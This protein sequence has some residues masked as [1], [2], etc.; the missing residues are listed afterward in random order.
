MRMRT[1]RT[2]PYAGEERRSGRDRRERGN[3]LFHGPVFK[4][5]RSGTRR[6]AD[7]R[8]VVALD[9]YS[10]SL[11]VAITIVLCLSLLD[12]L[13]TLMLISDGARE[14]N[15]VMAH[16]LGY[17]PRVFLLVKYGLTA[18]SAFIVVVFNE[19]LTT[20]YRFGGRTF[21]TLFSALFGSILIWQWYLFSI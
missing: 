13:F 12:A 21:L 10:P 14:L 2:K 5:R 17:G 16:Y 18:A 1:P 6:A 11:F 9:R 19:V 20:R 4:G 7:R 15:P 8:R 3:F